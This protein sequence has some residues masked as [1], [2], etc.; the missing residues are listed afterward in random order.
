[1]EKSHPAS[2]ETDYFAAIFHSEL[3]QKTT[4]TLSPFSRMHLVTSSG[5]SNLLRG[6][7][8]VLFAFTLRQSNFIFSREHVPYLLT[9]GILPAMKTSS[10]FHS[11]PHKLIQESQLIVVKSLANSSE[12][13]TRQLRKAERMIRHTLS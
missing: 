10:I 5:V 3:Y 6:R 12:E 4:K 7:F 9:Q 13:K 1:M 2:E 11:L 8:E